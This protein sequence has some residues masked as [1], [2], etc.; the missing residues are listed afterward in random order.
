MEG[1]ERIS[2]IKPGH[3]MTDIEGIPVDVTRIGEEEKLASD[4]KSTDDVTKLL[5]V[6][7]KY[8][9][10]FY[11]ALEEDIPKILEVFRVADPSYRIVNGYI[12]RKESLILPVRE[13]TATEMLEGAQIASR[14]HFHL[15]VQFVHYTPRPEEPGTHTDENIL[16]M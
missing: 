7:D 6:T 1:L 8:K 3:Y 11:L 16:D 9:E 2:E 5:R 13:F 10:A 12:L 14:R 15:Y 4:T